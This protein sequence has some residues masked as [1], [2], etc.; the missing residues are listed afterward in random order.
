MESVRSCILAHFDTG[1]RFDLLAHCYET[2]KKEHYAGLAK[3]L[4]EAARNGDE[5]CKQVFKVRLKICVKEFTHYFY[6]FLMIV[7][8]L[9]LSFSYIWTL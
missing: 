9:F 5:L 1:D 7:Y 6:Y 4:S 8:T 3:G 2:F